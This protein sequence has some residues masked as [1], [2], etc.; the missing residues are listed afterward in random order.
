MKWL[1]HVDVLASYNKPLPKGLKEDVGIAMDGA[2]VKHFSG[3]QLVTSARVAHLEMRKDRQFVSFEG[4]SDG[5]YRGKEGQVQF[6]TQTANWSA[7]VK[8]LAT[9]SISRVWDKN[10][11]LKVSGFTVDKGTSILQ[12]P[13]VFS[14]KFFG[15]LVT[16]TGLRYNLKTESWTLANIEW[17]GELPKEMQDGVSK[18]KSKWTIK[19]P[20]GSSSDGK[21][22]TYLKVTATDGEVIVKADK[23]VHELKS[24]VMT[25]TGNVSYFSAKADIAADT[26]TIYRKEKRALAVGNVHALLRS[27][28]VALP[29]G[30]IREIPPFR[31]ELPS[32]LTAAAPPTQDVPDLRDPNNLRKYPVNA[33]ATKVEYWYGK[34]NKRAKMD[35]KVEAYQELPSGQWRRM[36]SPSANYDGEKDVMKFLSAAGSKQVRM[37]DSWQDD[38]LCRTL[39][40]STKDEDTSSWNAEDME[41]DIYTQDEDIPGGGGSK[42][43]VAPSGGGGGKGVKAPPSELKI[44]RAHV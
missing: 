6:T 25:C 3:N 42:K 23:A 7:A 24:D 32:G 27:K 12:V 35:G 44:G 20:G 43:P 1:I 28:D 39:T 17:M 14:G 10:V 2:M 19:A 18:P 16:A 26:V 34:G 9:Q 8:Q 4:I 40:V 11:D 33:V 37:K 36:T 22:S 15:G 31:P 41:G 5:V 13:G 30:A 38:I 29:T 21:V